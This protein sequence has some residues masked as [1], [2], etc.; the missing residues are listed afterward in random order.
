MR[1]LVT[2][3]H[4]FIGSHLT[5][6]C[7]QIVLTD[8]WAPRILIGKGMPSKFRAARVRFSTLRARDGILISGL[9]EPRRLAVT[10]ENTG[11]AVEEEIILS[12]PCEAAIIFRVLRDGR[13]VD[14]AFHGESVSVRVALAEGEK[15]ELVVEG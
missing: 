2:G 7:E 8:F 14:H 4:G 11:E 10:L 3:A 15:T 6:A 1:V 12:V 9:S 5:A 13:E